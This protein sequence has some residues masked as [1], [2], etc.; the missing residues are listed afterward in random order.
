MSAGDTKIF[1][2]EGCPGPVKG[3]GGEGMVD[4]KVWYV[5]NYEM[6]G[7]EGE[8]SEWMMLQ[9][10]GDLEKGLDMNGVYLTYC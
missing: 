4:G 9:Q 2:S 1:N 3:E 8:W 5:L 10:D 6:E 7:V